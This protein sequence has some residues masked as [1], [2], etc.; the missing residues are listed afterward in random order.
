MCS[1]K[2]SSSV[3]STEIWLHSE[4]GVEAP[5]IEA[6]LLLLRFFGSPCSGSDEGGGRGGGGNGAQNAMLTG[7]FLSEFCF[8]PTLSMSDKLLRCEPSGVASNTLSFP[9]HERFFS[10]PIGGSGVWVFSSAELFECA[11][12]EILGFVFG[13]L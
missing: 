7:R 2:N 11:G 9:E 12:E 6:R 1:L 10:M 8:V 4:R 13:L 3:L 5:D